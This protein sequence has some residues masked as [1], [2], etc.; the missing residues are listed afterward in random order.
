LLKEAL[1]VNE[2]IGAA[3]YLLLALAVAVGF[4]AAFPKA[5]RRQ[6]VNSVAPGTQSPPA[7]VTGEA[8]RHNA[9]AAHEHALPWVIPPDLAP[10]NKTSAI[11]V[12]EI[13]Q[14]LEAIEL[15]LARSTGLA[16]Q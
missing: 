11:T 7:P 9:T 16:L 13:A 5:G 10:E 8:Q 4:S 15:R 14:R 12:E 3:V 2:A 6:K 1:P